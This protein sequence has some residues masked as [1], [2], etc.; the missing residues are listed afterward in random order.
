MSYF[1]QGADIRLTTLPPYFT[2]AKRNIRATEFHAYHA[3]RLRQPATSIRFKQTSS[4]HF[5][6]TNNRFI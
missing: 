2:T 4:C 1:G 3:F 6:F 5:S